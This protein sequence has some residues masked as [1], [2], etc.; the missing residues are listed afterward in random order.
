M[1]QRAH[2]GPGY[3]SVS[4]SLVPPA[5]SIPNRPWSRRSGGAADAGL[6]PLMLGLCLDGRQTRFSLRSGEHAGKSLL[7]VFIFNFCILNKFFFSTGK[8]K[9]FFW[10]LVPANFFRRVESPYHHG[11]P[12]SEQSPYPAEHVSCWSTNYGAWPVHRGI[13]VHIQTPIP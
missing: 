6:A 12:T 2:R 7:V 5:Y 3:R 9:L 13:G 11:R 8:V 10:V 1:I 4:D